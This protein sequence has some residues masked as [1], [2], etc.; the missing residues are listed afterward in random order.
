MSKQEVINAIQEV[1]N[2][3]DAEAVVELSVDR[4]E[5][6]LIKEKV[7]DHMRTVLDIV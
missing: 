4:Y 5:E 2:C 1:K 6:L 7:Y 3:V